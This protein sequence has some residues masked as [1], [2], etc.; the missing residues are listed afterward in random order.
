MT[1]WRLCRISRQLDWSKVGGVACD[2]KET[3]VRITHFLVIHCRRGSIAYK[4]EWNGLSVVF[5]GDAGPE[6]ISIEQAKNGIAVQDSS[7]TPQGA[8]GYLLSKIDP[9]PQSRSRHR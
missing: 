1:R 5:S 4:L 6:K 2:N 3:G 8:F 7:R 9:R